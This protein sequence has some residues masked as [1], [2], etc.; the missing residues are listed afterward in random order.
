LTAAKAIVETPL[1][2]ITRNFERSIAEDTVRN[3][4]TFHR[5]IHA[6]L[7]QGRLPDGKPAMDVESLNE[8]VYADL[9]LTPGS[10]PWLGLLPAGTYSALPNDGV[11]AR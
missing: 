5:Q 2:R 9:F 1:M 10:D 11:C 7:A 4:Y 8:R 6:W 3:E